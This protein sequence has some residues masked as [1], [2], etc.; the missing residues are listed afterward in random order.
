MDRFEAI[1]PVLTQLIQFEGQPEAGKFV[2]KVKIRGLRFAHTEWYFP[3]DFVSAKNKP[4][5]SPEP[6][7]DVG[8]FAQ[9]AIGVPG[10]VQGEGM[11]ECTFER[12][13]FS[14]LGSYALELKRGCQK[15]RIVDCEFSDLG[16]GGI[17][18]GDTRIAASADT[19]TCENEITGCR[20]FDGGKVFHSAEGIWIGQSPGNRITNNLIHDFYYTGISIGW[21]WGYKPAAASNNIVEFNHV[22]HIGKK[23]DGDGPILSDMGGIYTLGRQPGTRI[24]NNLWHDMAGLNYGGWGIYFDEGS[25]G[26]VAESNVVYRTTH[27]G[28]HQH[29]GETNVVR[30]NIFAFGRDAQIQ[31]TRAEEHIGFTF[32][33][34]IVY[35]D[36]GVLLAG[37]W[38]GDNFRMDNNIYF[39]AR[40][41]SAPETMRF[42]GATLE[43]WRARGHDVH[44]LIA[45]PLFVATGDGGFRLQTSSP[46]IKIGFQSIAPMEI[47]K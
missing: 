3:A 28:F 2:E 31:R 19:Q 14:G 41:G 15:N 37:D 39:D 21:T 12:C 26:I 30:N 4:K 36:S 27:G 25:S 23:S 45:D 18:I 5:V 17:K 38:A 32:E 8:G 16:G 46:A 1:A 29:Y 44:S 40:A 7:L 24:C 13:T 33:H 9:A 42:A 43:Q 35:F 11:R 10:A 22:H 6:A 47:G 34:N 20:I